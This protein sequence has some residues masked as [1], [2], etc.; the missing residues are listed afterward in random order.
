MPLV[1]HDPVKVL[2]SALGD[3]RPLVRHSAAEALGQLD[4]RPR[5][6]VPP[7]VQTLRDRDVA[8]R[9]AAGQALVQ[10]GK[11][12]VPFLLAALKEDDADW[13]T[14]IIVILGR[15]GAAAREAVPALE[16]LR[17]DETIGPPAADALARI[18]RRWAWHFTPESLERGLLWFHL[19]LSL[20]LLTLEIVFDVSGRFGLAQEISLKAAAAW[21]L[22]GAG[23]GGL[24]GGLCRGRRTALASALVLGYGGA[25]TGALLGGL[26]GSVFQTVAAALS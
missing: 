11:P 8:V 26:L 21:G 19:F 2:I 12:A 14:A 9:L 25:V 15:I 4:E 1:D 17:D 10:L 13:Q 3:K 5:D 22:L 6:V 23:L 18:Q 20:G 7:L 24:V 16:G